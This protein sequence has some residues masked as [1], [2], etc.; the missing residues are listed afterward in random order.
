ML[1]LNEEK[2]IKEFY[3][4]DYHCTGFLP[5]EAKSL[6]CLGKFVTCIFSFKKIVVGFI[7]TPVI[8]H[9]SLFIMVSE[10]C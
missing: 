10:H 8:I 5:K 7:T 1:V 3:E 6:P 9:F 4:L 2:L